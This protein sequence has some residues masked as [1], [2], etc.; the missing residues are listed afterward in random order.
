MV[1]GFKVLKNSSAY[2]LG[3]K[4]NDDLQRVYGIA[5]PKQAMLES[6]LKEQ[7]ELG[8]RDHRTIGQKQDL[9][10]F[11]T[12]SPGS[13]L[14]Y[15]HGTVILNRLQDLMRSEYKIRGYHEVQSPSIYSAELWKM[16]GHYFKYKENIF[17]IK[18]EG[19]EYGLK[20]M[21]CPGHCVMFGLIQRSYKDL[22]YRM[23]DFGILHR[24]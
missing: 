4:E 17:W 8:K 11:T 15:P 16:S 13:A 9:F 22:P 21:N 10:H 24:N 5:F 18:N 12:H 6:Y 23:A 2:W 7:E 20:P 3:K 1:K 14:F 19:E